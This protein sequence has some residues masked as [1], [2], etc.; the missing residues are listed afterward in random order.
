MAILMIMV[1]PALIAL[2]AAFGAVKL[3]SRLPRASST[4]VRVLLW[5]GILCLCLIAGGIGSCYATIF[6]RGFKI[7]EQQ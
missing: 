3:G 1:V 4:S 5:C 2:A 7:H 6:T